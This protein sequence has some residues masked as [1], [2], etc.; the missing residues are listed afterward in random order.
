M[1]LKHVFGRVLFLSVLAAS[2]RDVA[3]IGD[4][5]GCGLDIKYLRTLSHGSVADVDA[6]IGL[7]VAAYASHFEREQKKWFRP[8]PRLSETARDEYRAKLIQGQIH[9]GAD[10]PI[11]Y[12]A[13]HGNLE[14][15]TWLLEHGASPSATSPV[16]NT[17]VFTRCKGLS[18]GPPPGLSE[19]R[20][21]ERQLEAYQL[22]IAR[23]ADPNAID[24]FDSIRGCLSHEMLPLLHKL[25]ARVT[26]E[27]FES[28]VWASRTGQTIYESRWATVRQLAQWQSFDF[29]G[30]AFEERLLSMLDARSGMSDY[31]AAV[32]LTRRVDTVV[33]LSPGI[34]PGRPARPE[35]VPKNFVPTRERCFFPE[36]SAYRDF[37]FIALWRDDVSE[38]AKPNPRAR[39]PGL[40][41]RVKVG[42]TRAPVLLALVNNRDTP[43]TWQI[44]RASGANVLGVIVLD[45][46]S[47]QRGGMDRLSFD[48]LRPAY[49]GTS[50]D[51]TVQALPQGG[52][53]LRN[54]LRP[55]WP[56][57]PDS[58]SYNPFRLRG[59]PRIMTSQGDEF[60]VG[61]LSPS[62]VLIAWP[63]SLRV[64][65]KATRQ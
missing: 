1:T 47:N 40:T 7:K 9:C 65:T 45:V 62:E 38:E 49:L 15:L 13:G 26:R 55:Y 31:D 34:A 36:I 41:T 51:C 25:G 14:V 18:F 39:T 27:A 58:W 23:G 10:F 59:E 22:L 60:V 30:T 35:D 17:N 20:A 6:V 19:Q 64:K 24:A 32:E 63:E 16:S 61:D 2:A 57:K 43:T 56:P 5:G 12:A 11:D 42:R 54:E 8:K 21:L 29:R 33:R 52:Q 50:S 48:P 53:R 4:S 44:S 37:E 46:H 3:A 28:R